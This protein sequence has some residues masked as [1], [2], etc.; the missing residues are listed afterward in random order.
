MSRFSDIVESEVDITGKTY[1]DEAVRDLWG[2]C[3]LTFN[4]LCDFWMPIVE[5]GRQCMNYAL[6]EIFD[7]VTRG[8]YELIQEKICI[9]PRVLKQ[10]MNVAVG[11]L[12]QARRN[13]KVVSE[14]KGGA[15]E[16]YSANAVLKF[17]EKEI[18][19]KSLITKMLF[20]GCLTG[21]PQVAIGEQAETG[22]GDPLGG[23][24]IFVPPWDSVVMNKLE[25]DLKITDLMY[26]C[27]KT[28]Q[29]LIDENPDREDEI[30]EHFKELKDR[31]YGM[32]GCLREYRLSFD[33]SRLLNQAVFNGEQ[34]FA[35]DGRIVCVERMCFQK[36][37]TE[38]AIRRD[39]GG[40]VVDTQVLPKTW[41]KQRID[42]WKKENQGY[43]F[44]RKNTKLLW[45]SRW[46]TD[47]LFLK[48]EPHFFQ[49]SDV[50]GDPIANAVVFVPQIIDGK[51]TGPGPDDRLLVLMKAIAET[52]FLHDIRC[53]SGDLFLYKEGAVVNSDDLATELSVGNGMVAVDGE[54]PGAVR[55]YVDILK[56]T[57]NTTYGEYSGRV[58]AMLDAA[59]MLSP[60]ARG[61]IVSDRVSAKTRQTDIA[62][63]MVG[64]SIVAE[65]MNNAIE[66]LRN[67]E[68][69]LIPYCFTEEQEIQVHDDDRGVELNLTVNKSEFDETGERRV[70]ANDLT[71]A[72][73]RWRLV[74]GDD[75]PTA[76]QAELNEMLVFWNTTAPVLIDADESLMTLASVLMSMSNRTA[77]E[78]GRVI[79]E[80]AQVNAQ[81][82]S[83]QK[84]METM[85][86]VQM[87][88]AKA[89]AEMTKS[90]RAGFSF[91][92]TPDD[93]ANIPGLYKILVASNYINPDSNM[94]Q[95]PGG[96]NV[97]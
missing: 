8:Q 31:S 52:E 34:G 78:I 77:R 30:T 12:L 60:A 86:D 64:Y 23:M 19:E 45:Q 80:K 37:D 18:G 89:S 81:A 93:L 71:S 94:F 16:I 67:L 66:K 76:K 39:D 70:V 33:E 74:D 22:F 62:M 58:D 11:Q 57:P 32:A 92:I 96:N 83:Q 73:W 24:S 1:T 82:M 41:G 2:K 46:T 47:G 17:I 50:R 69:M 59:D 28:R 85:A 43:Q 15:E 61:V 4:S 21:Y 25:D 53:G 88:Q 26:I 72:R 36:V 54:L 38:V 6:G 51:P 84:M 27:R 44:S 55:D 5:T 35:A 29:E 56:R 9:E 90:K 3:Q 48:N 63:T 91:S 10:R 20:N 75:S 79:A 13:G 65:N 49:E 97:N 68:C 42:Q 14:S 95:N 87:K 7:P 40:S